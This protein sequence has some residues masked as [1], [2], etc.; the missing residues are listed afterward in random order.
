MPYH[1]KSMDSNGHFECPCED[2]I[3][4]AS[5]VAYYNTIEEYYYAT[6]Y[7][8]PQQLYLLTDISNVA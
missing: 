5:G 3:Y 7:S 2:N 4:V 1:Q 8:N 6:L